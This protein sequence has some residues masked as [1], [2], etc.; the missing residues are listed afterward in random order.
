M[1]WAKPL[2]GNVVKTVGQPEA[3]R[4]PPQPGDPG[5]LLPI[6]LSAQLPNQPVP[7]GHE[8]LGAL[9]VKVASYLF[10]GFVGIGSAVRHI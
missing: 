5:G 4:G 6:L 1:R 2:A 3:E 7:R 10:E 9:F 8:V